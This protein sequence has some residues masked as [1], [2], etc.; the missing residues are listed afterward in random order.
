MKSLASATALASLL[1]CCAST[2][3][4]HPTIGGPAT[5][6]WYNP[7][8][9]G[10]GYGIDIQGDTMIVTTY[11]YTASGDPIWYLSSG[12]YSYSTGVFRSSYDSYSDGQC[13][14]CSPRAP[15]VHGNAGGPI[16]IT[17][18]NNVT[19]TLSYPGGSTNIKKYNYGVSAGTDNLYGEWS[20]SYNISGL[21]GGDWIVFNEPYTGSNGTTYAS[22]FMD[23]ASQYAALGYFDT[24]ANAFFVLISV[25]SF[26]DFYQL[27]LDDH[28]GLGAAW[29]LSDGEDPTGDGSPSVA[30]RLLFRPELTG[31]TGNAEKSA[32]SLDR[33]KATQQSVGPV[34]QE[35]ATALNKLRRARAEKRAGL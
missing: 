31:T 18:H 6:L 4:A 9:G 17:F 7:Q 34:N 33:P 12:P 19:A 24:S 32:P 21:V 13:F 35:A 8:E 1:F 23:S 27:G 14:G 3:A 15:V 2:Y 28:R 26:D 25:G 22:G 5:G 29:I 11:I 20:F 16:T 10:R 30:S